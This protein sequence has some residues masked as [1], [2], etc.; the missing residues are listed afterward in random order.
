MRA[1][2]MNGRDFFF[3]G[4][5]FGVTCFLSFITSKRQHSKQQQKTVKK[6]LNS[7]GSLAWYYHTNEPFSGGVGVL[8]LTVMLVA[9]RTHWK[10]S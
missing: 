8:A 4:L 3:F 1:T 2:S 9:G 10:L 6:C 5:N 7:N